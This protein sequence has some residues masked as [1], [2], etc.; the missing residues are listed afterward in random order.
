MST[1]NCH[2]TRINRIDID[3]GLHG[4]VVGVAGPFHDDVGRDAEGEG[5]DDEGAAAGV[6]TDQFPLGLDLVGADV[7]LFFISSFL[8]L[9]PLT[10]LTT[11]NNHEKIS[12]NPCACCSLHN[13]FCP[14]SGKSFPEA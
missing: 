11:P 10:S 2:Q 8:Y 9:C 4:F 14:G 3:I 13:R 6:G 12:Y 7:A 5:V 1:Q